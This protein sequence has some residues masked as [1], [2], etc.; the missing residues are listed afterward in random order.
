[1]PKAGVAPGG[2]K[3]KNKLRRQQAY[4]TLK[5]AKESAKRDERF[6]RKREEAKDVSLREERLARN[7][8]VTIEQKRQWDDGVGN[9]EDVLGW[10]VDVERLAKKRKL[11]QEAAEQAAEQAAADEE[12]GVL[13]QLKKR[14]AEEEEDEEDSEEDEVDSMLED[15]SEED[16]DVSDSDSDASRSRS[17]KRAAP[18]PKRAASPA[19]STATNLEL[20]PDFLKQ[21]FPTLFSPHETP[22]I[23]VTTSLRST[24]HKEAE[25]IA[26]FL[27]NSTYIPRSAHAHAHK[28]SV[29]EIAGF[30][31]N[32]GYT[33]LCVLMED[34]KK[35]A[36][37]D[38][39]HLPAGPHFHFT[40]TN[41]VEGKK[42][43]GHGRATGHVPGKHHHLTRFWRPIA[44]SSQNSSSTT[45]ARPSVS[46]PPTSSSPSGPP[47]RKSKAAPSSPCTTSAI[48]SSSANIATSSARSGR[49][50]NPLW[51]PMERSSRALRTSR[52]VCKSWVR[53]SRSSCGESIAVSNGRVARNGNG[54]AKWRNRGRGSICN[55]VGVEPELLGKETRDVER[56]YMSLHTINARYPGVYLSMQNLAQSCVCS[57]TILV[58]VAKVQ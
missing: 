1:M 31:A 2:L 5:K 57:P 7:I 11:E 33:S 34:Q 20:S 25:V 51:A 3:P 8:P 54:R 18:P 42:I 22:K 38:I 9:E 27:P 40:I 36:G 49:P 43:P 53:A 30:A 35:P 45:S 17:K 55:C 16:S 13:A 46:S 19:Q 48:T 50:R 12:N 24:L 21:K 37:L 15:D 14:D 29:K 4:Q 44:N 56:E 39:I 28:Y 6:R 32:R 41:W 10:A 47:P 58:M 52:P 26:D 23:L